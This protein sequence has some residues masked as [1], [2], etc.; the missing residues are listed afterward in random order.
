MDN[1]VRRT[2]GRDMKTRQ[3]PATG[4]RLLRRSPVRGMDGEALHPFAP[5]SS[6]QAGRH[7]LNVEIEVRSLAPDLCTGE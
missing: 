1:I 6:N 3:S 4:A 5:G 7:A 2:A